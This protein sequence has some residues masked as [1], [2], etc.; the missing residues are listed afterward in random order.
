[1]TLLERLTG[2]A[3]A[4]AVEAKPPQTRDKL[5]EEVAQAKSELSK[6]LAELREP[7]EA[8]QAAHELAQNREREARDALMRATS[9]VQSARNDFQR[10][11]ERLEKE[12]RESAPPTID[13]FW[14]WLAEQ[15]KGL[16]RLDAK[17]DAAPLASLISASQ[18][19]VQHLRL[20]TAE[21]AE[22]RIEAL[23]AEIEAAQAAAS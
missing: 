18:R 11:I 7:A 21:D 16:E 19:E 12:I 3:T 22:S 14:R 20:L 15:R 5:I 10:R 13:A 6:R 2:R 17:V 4:A 8:A 9:A 23:V 1:M